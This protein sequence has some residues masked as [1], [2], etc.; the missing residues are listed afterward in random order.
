L[1]H[2]PGLTFFPHCGFHWDRVAE[3]LIHLDGWGH[4]PEDCSLSFKIGPATVNVGLVTS[5]FVLLMEPIYGD[6]DV[7]QT[8]FIEFS[9]VRLDG[10]TA[11]E[12][13]VYLSRA[14]FYLNS[15]YL[16]PLRTS[17][18]VWH[19]IAPDD[20]FWGVPL[21][22]AAKVGR[23]RVLRRADFRANEPLCLYNYACSSHGEASFLGFYRVLEYFFLKAL[24]LDVQI[25]RNNPSVGTRDLIA[26]ART[27]GELPHLERLL[28]MVM[29]PSQK[30]R[31]AEYAVRRGLIDTADFATLVRS[32]YAFRNG[33]VHAKEFE[34]H[35]TYVP[36]PLQENSTVDSWTYIAR[37][38]ATAVIRRLNAAT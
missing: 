26:I 2:I 21:E 36:D 10:V 30:R 7:G 18:S 31:L 29:T 9:S 24:E 25:A 27:Q 28:A 19:L 35:R 17:V 4:W 6:E 12:A 14:L 1:P 13:P 15:D 3:F 8:D 20:D 22:Y 38:S 23:A 34:I 32:M 11:K 16:R 37:E 33:L 5:A